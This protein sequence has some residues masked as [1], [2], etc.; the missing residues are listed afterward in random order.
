MTTLAPLSTDRQKEMEM[1]AI[2]TAVGQA[3]MAGET[4]SVFIHP[5][6]PISHDTIDSTFRKP[7]IS[8]RRSATDS[9]NQYELAHK[10]D[11]AKATVTV[12][13]CPRNDWR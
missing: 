13:D 11:V 12:F 4:V 3:L 7:F 2:L 8:L 9:A 6:S 5:T 10:H 1:E